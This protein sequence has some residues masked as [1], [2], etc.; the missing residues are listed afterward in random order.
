V[1]E[2]FDAQLIEMTKETSYFELL[3]KLWAEQRPFL[4][5]EQDVVPGVTLVRDMWSCPCELCC[6]CYEPSAPLNGWAALG[7]VKF[8][9]DV[10]RRVP[11]AMAR[12]ARLLPERNWMHLDLALLDR[13]LLAEEGIKPHVH[14][15]FMLHLK[16]GRP[17]RISGPV[18]TVMDHVTRSRLMRQTARS[19]ESLMWDSRGPKPPSG[20]PDARGWMGTAL[21]L[22]DG[23]D[24]LPLTRP[25]CT[26]S[27]AGSI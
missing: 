9:G 14:K 26:P 8:S 27:E 3:E 2:H 21:G 4:L 24:T 23:E 16:S 7:L 1:A 20:K 25:S 15:P 6:G 13:V 19:F 10:L 12:V 18:E 17:T 22:R 11:D 5:L